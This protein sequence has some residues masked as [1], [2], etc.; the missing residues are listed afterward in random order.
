MK[1]RHYDPDLGK[2]VIS[3]ASNAEDLELTN[4]AYTDG[5]G[6]SVSINQGIT[7]LTN[8]VKKIEDNL[9]WIYLNG[10][11]GGGSGPGT[12]GSDSIK[13][14]IREGTTL[15]T[16]TSTVSFN[17]MIN[18]GTISRSFTIVI[19]DVSTGK[20]LS[21]LR[22]FSLTNIPIELSNLTNSVNLE[23]SAYDGSG[24]T[25]IPLHV[26]VIYGAIN[27]SLQRVPDKTIIRGAISDVPANFTLTNNISGGSSKFVFKVNNTLIDEVENI[28]VSPR[29]LTYNIR[30]IIFGDLFPNVTAGDRFNFEAHATTILNDT[31]LKSNIIKFDV[32]VTEANSLV[33]VTNDISDKPGEYTEYPQG[34][35]LNFNYYLSYAPSKYSTFNIDYIVK[36]SSDNILLS[37]RIPN[38]N[39][40]VNSVF[41]VS[42][43]NLDVK[44]MN[45]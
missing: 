29:S 18:N 9:A 39:K 12:G 19:K 34:S 15:Y 26:S 8:K 25:A 40:G 14:E 6:G 31:E 27:L 4:P 16:S 42:T 35:Q 2:W 3:A 23:I 38:V 44:K 24:N 33:I 20:T 36:S 13:I 45:L 7:K 43:V 37:G 32:T 10:A 5:E 22:K 21:T 30:N 41:S 1:I 17:L 11:H 28:R